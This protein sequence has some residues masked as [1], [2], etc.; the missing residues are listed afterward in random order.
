[1]ETSLLD[2]V[3]MGLKGLCLDGQQS[4]ITGGVLSSKSIAGLVEEK[5][6]GTVAMA[7][8]FWC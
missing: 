6:K 3:R 5:L 7:G 2:Y 8:D 4:D 1:V